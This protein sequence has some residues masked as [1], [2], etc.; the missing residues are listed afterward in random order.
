ML[1]KTRLCAKACHEVNRR[2][3]QD[4]SIHLVFRYRKQASTCI[5]ARKSW[6]RVSES[7]LSDGAHYLSTGKENIT[8][9]LL[10][11]R[12]RGTMD[13]RGS[14]QCRFLHTRTARTRYKPRLL[15]RH[16]RRCRRST[17][18]NK[19]WYSDGRGVGR[20]NCFVLE[21]EKR[22]NNKNFNLENCRIIIMR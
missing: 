20:W 22:A 6:R 10:F 8:R 7:W 16:Q 14:G 17:R 18:R 15:F 1:T 19:N 13:L 5:C 3:V 21:N 2:V 11:R 12:L 9:V 4:S